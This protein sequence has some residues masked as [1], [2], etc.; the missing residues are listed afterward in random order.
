MTNTMALAQIAVTTAFRHS[1]SAVAR[2]VAA[3]AVF[4]ALCGAAN[5]VTMAADASAKPYDVMVMVAAGEAGMAQVVVSYP[6]VVDHAALQAAIE[7]LGRLAEFTPSRLAIRDAPLAK[8]V[9]ASGTD[10]QFDAPGLIGSAGQLPVGP[11]ARSLSQWDHMRLVFMLDPK[12]P[13]TGPT[14]VTAEGLAVRLVNRVATYEYDVERISRSAA[15]P[16]EA[17]ATAGAARPGVPVDAA[18][19]ERTASR[20]LPSFAHQV[21][22]AA[23]IGLPSGLLVGWLLFGWRERRWRRRPAAARASGVQPRPSTEKPGSGA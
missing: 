5:T 2:V 21:L 14:D 23:L 9:S 8:Q 16:G 15:P 10:A 13:F 17:E 7:G 19:G 4:L 3:V 1:P 6:N 18:N 12:Y 20:Q 11:I 22:P